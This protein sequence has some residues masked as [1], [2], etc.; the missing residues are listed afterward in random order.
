MAGAT[1]SVVQVFIEHH[2]DGLRVGEPTG[3]GGDAPT[4]GGLSRILQSDFDQPMDHRT[5]GGR[6]RE[7]ARAADSRAEAE[8]DRA[9][10]RTNPEM[11]TSCT[12]MIAVQGR[13]CQPQSRSLIPMN[14]EEQEVARGHEG[15]NALEA[16]LAEA[17]RRSPFRYISRRT[18]SIGTCIGRDGTCPMVRGGSSQNRWTE[19]RP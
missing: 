16:S 19:P 15:A 12:C 14:E 7:G 6:I 9:P 3:T 1:S 8:W 18:R 5:E 13:G 17:V 2:I 11:M 10:P 4:A